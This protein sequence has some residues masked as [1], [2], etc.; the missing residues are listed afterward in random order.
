M[1]SLNHGTSVGQGKSLRLGSFLPKVP[2][3]MFACYLLHW[4]F[5]A[6]RNSENTTENKLLKAEIFEGNSYKKYKNSIIKT[7]YFRTRAVEKQASNNLVVSNRFFEIFLWNL[8][9][10]HTRANFETPRD[11][12]SLIVTNPRSDHK[13]L[14]PEKLT[15]QWKIQHI[16]AIY[17]ETCFFFGGISMLV[18]GWV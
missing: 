17:K 16:D 10:V 1:G 9:F 14:Q 3:Y 5:Q 11:Q 13:D 18:F 15:W 7:G 2:K 12:E 6:T 8:F 4:M